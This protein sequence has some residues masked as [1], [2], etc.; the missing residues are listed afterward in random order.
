MKIL[1]E[2]VEI[3]EPNTHKKDEFLFGDV[4]KLYVRTFFKPNINQVKNL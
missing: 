4:I 1:N 3:L 2:L